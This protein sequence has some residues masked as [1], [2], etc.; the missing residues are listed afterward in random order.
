MDPLLLAVLVGCVVAFL[1]A[2]GVGAADLA[3]IMSTT[4]SSKAINVR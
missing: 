1:T 3:N 2:W 4:L